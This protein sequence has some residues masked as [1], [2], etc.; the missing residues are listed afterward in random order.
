MKENIACFGDSLIYGFPYNND[1]SWLNI[2]NKYS[3]TVNCINYGECGFTCDDVYDQMQS[4]YLPKNVNHI[5]VLSGANDILQERPIKNI[6]SDLANIAN[7]CADRRFALCII[8]PFLTAYQN[9]NEKLSLLRKEIFN[10]TFSENFVLDLQ[11]A[12][13]QD[14][15]IDSDAF[16]DGIHP[17]SQTYAKIGFYAIPFLDKWI[18]RSRE[19]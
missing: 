1:S 16:F 10:R 4:F 12:I 13:W 5:L 3:N 6:I 19:I 8:L 18:E 15:K 9:Y 7:W 11:P 2:V 14:T 17:T